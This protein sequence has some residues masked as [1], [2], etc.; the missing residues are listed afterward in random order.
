MP[1]PVDKGHSP[2][3]A[4]PPIVYLVMILDRVLGD[5][6][7]HTFLGGPGAVNTGVELGSAWLNTRVSQFTD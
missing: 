6:T 7:G 5:G 2:P 3:A 1:P 4:C